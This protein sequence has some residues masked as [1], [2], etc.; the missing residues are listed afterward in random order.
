MSS[1]QG[2]LTTVLNMSITASYV[3]VVVILIRFFLRKAP[4]IFSYVLWSVVL[5]RLL[6]PLSLTSDFSF[7]GLIDRNLQSGADVLDYVP[8]HNAMTPRPTMPSGSAGFEPGV[9]ASLPQ[10]TPM[11]SSSPMPIGMDILSLLW[12]AGIA[13]LMSYSIISYIRTKR[14]LQTATL[15]KDTIYESDRLTT[16]FVCGFIRPK[17]YVPL[18]VAGAD[19][20]YILAHEE[21]HIKRRD[22]LLKPLAFFALILHWFNPLIWL[23]FVLMSRDMEMSCD[24]SVLSKMGEEAKRGYSSSLLALSVKR[25][26]LFTINPLAFGE[27]HVKTRIKNILNYK[28]P[29]FWVLIALV[30]VMG[31]MVFT[32]VADPADQEPDLS[33]LNPNNLASLLMQGEGVQIS[34]AGYSYPIIVSSAEL[35]KWL[36]SAADDWKKKEV[37]TPF[38]LTPSITIHVNADNE[39]RFFDEE[40]TLAMIQSGDH[41]RYYAIPKQDFQV[42]QQIALLA[43]P[44]IQSLTMSKWEKGEEVASVTS[45]DSTILEMV[46][47]LAQEEENSP[48]LLRYS[49]VND[50][51]DV[52]DYMRIVLEGPNA[53]Y[54]Y[55]LYTEDGKN[56]AIEKPYERIYK[57]SPDTAQAI[58][59]LFKKAGDRSQARAAYD[60][61]KSLNII[62]SSPLSSSNP[63]DYIRT[64]QDE[65]EKIL[66]YGG[67]EALQYMLNQFEQGKGEGLRGHIMMEL[68]KDI[69]RERNGITDESLSPQ[70]WYEALSKQKRIMLPDY[71]HEGEDEVEKL[72]YRT[73]TERNSQPQRGFTV[74]APKI[75]GSYEE[76]EFLKV[77]V[78]TYS[79][80]YTIYNDGVREIGGSVIPSAHT[81]KKD[82]KGNYVLLTYEQA[83]DGANFFTSI[84]SFCTLPVSGKPISG[85]AEK[86]IHYSNDEELL[87]LQLE[88]LTKHL[89]K[90]G[91][92]NPIIVKPGNNTI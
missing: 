76:G 66:K 30:I 83:G 92:T 11:T 55:F 77:F 10:I 20:D 12:L 54:T 65:Y 88:N 84:R 3:A 87:K 31:A 38:D 45:I 7:L 40:P 53:A 68:C 90:N 73:E 75:F 49:S 42:I 63:Q 28:K 5:F 9:N 61:E 78:T 47:H 60:L 71:T 4:K 24:E 64:H 57:I 41:Y 48:F 74:V 15:V 33:F 13:A 89:R 46:V 6:C 91:V 51:P 37:P 86:I 18:G 82:S 2:A 80:T 23:S 67:E 26:G 79:S 72:V 16:A 62:M 50:T 36:S 1:L 19:L 59:D 56:Y 21:T 39:I 58:I 25:N 44:K 17:I 35:G 69:L 52:A 22:Y 32:L 8:Q 14:L 29:R 70:E 43:Y 34:E 27:L 81:Y 85:L